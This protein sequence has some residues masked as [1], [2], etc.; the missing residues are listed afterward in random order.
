[1]VYEHHERFD[2]S[3]YPRGLKGD[4]ISMGARVIAVA[5]VLDAMASHRPYRPA[6][7][8]DAAMRRLEEGRGSQ[9]DPPVADVCLD[10]FKTAQL[11]LEL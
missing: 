11:K 6:L 9:F 7:G 4:E 2:G 10:L 1:M 3:G 5:D 8:L